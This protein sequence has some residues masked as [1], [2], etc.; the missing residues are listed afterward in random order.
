MDPD[1]MAEWL[2]QLS[3]LEGCI[4]D[5]ERAMHAFNSIAAVPHGPEHEE[6]MR[7]ERELIAYMKKAIEIWRKS[8]G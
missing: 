6:I 7:L 4:E 2:A 3:F 5:V 1:S 8:P